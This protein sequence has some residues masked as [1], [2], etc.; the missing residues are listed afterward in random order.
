MTDGHV[1]FT[2]DLPDV[3]EMT[4]DATEPET[5]GA[6]WGDVLNNGEYV[7]ELRDDD[8]DGDHPDYEH[9][10]TV[11]YD[12]GTEHTIEGILGGEQYSVRIRTETE[13]KIGEWLEVEEKTKLVPSDYVTV[14]ETDETSVELSWTIENEFRGSHLIYRQREDYDYEGDPADTGRLTGTVADDDDE[15]VDESVSPDREY[16]YQVRTQTQWQYADS[17][18]TDP[19]TT[20]ETAL[21]DRSVPR[22][23]WYVEL[24]HP[25]G[26]TITPDVLDGATFSAEIRDQPTASIDIERNPAIYADSYEGIPI[27]VW[28]DGDRLPVEEVE[29]S[30]LEDDHVSLT[31]V[32][33]TALENDVERDVVDER[34]SEIV[35]TL[36]EDTD[37]EAN[38][39]VPEASIEEDVGVV[40]ADDE[41]TFEELLEALPIDEETIPLEVDGNTVKPLQTCAVID[42][43]GDITG[44]MYS[45]GAAQEINFSVSHEFG[46]KVPEE[47]LN[48]R[49]RRGGYENPDDGPT[50]DLLWNGEWFWQDAD[51]GSQDDPSWRRESWD[52]W[53]S[54]DVAD[55]SMTI[56]YSDSPDEGDGMFVDVVAFYDD[57]FHSSIDFSDEL[58]EPGGYL[59]GPSLYPDDPLEIETETLSQFREAIAGYLDVETGH[60]GGVDE[61]ALSADAGGSWIEAEDATSLEGEFYESGPHIKARF[62]LGADRDLEPQGATPRFGYEPQSLESIDIR[63]DFDDRPLVLNR[64]LEGDLGDVLDELADVSDAVWEVGVNADGELTLE[65]TWPG[66]RKAETPATGAM[67]PSVSKESAPILMARVRGGRTSTRQRVEADPGSWVD[68]RAENIIPGTETVEDS[69]GEEYSRG[70]D[71]EMENGNGRIR[72]TESG[73]ID[74]GEELHLEYDYKVSGEFEHE[75]Y[76]GDRRTRL[77]ETISD[78]S[79]ERACEQAAM[80]LVRELSTPRYEVSADF[81]SGEIRSLVEA[82]ELED[83]DV[84]VPAEYLLPYDM[85]IESD[86]DRVTFGTRRSSSEVFGGFESRLDSANDRV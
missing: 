60:G 36:L 84:D 72:M 80:Y 24:E 75:D 15:F 26:V 44:D 30:D 29:E 11:G 40:F 61:L 76:D 66:D 7:L 5:L 54:G 13:Y 65:W 62:G 59:P 73:A 78:L 48:L 53:G 10:A 27:R 41:L 58:H 3:E 28:K 16:Q 74:D 46:Y 17:E 34:V 35:E 64:I 56:Q 1:T 20:E 2:T 18:T 83:L 67:D 85:S 50:Y 22:G 68:L 25:E 19:V 79:T 37:L 86:R 12:E 71:Y 8:P 43:D 51:I 77:T 23:G 6:E 57:R 81:P 4:L 14:E 31:A 33:G 70:L 82:V 47:N 42:L 32:G 55:N 38:V 52:L 49:Y 69:D 39:D 63:A 45:G 9:E 21:E